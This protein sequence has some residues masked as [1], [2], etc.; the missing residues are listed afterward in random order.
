MSDPATGPS[1]SPVAATELAD[2][3]EVL[4]PGR[5]TRGGFEPRIT[6]E[7]GDGWTAEQVAAGFFD[8]Q[9]DAGS[10]DV[11]AVQF[12]R[13]VGFEAAPDAVAAVQA[14]AQL[15]VVSGPEPVTV[16]GM[17]GTRITVETTD[18]VDSQPPIF[19]QVLTVGAGPLS[20][21]SG[22][23][24]QVDLVDTPDGLLAVLVGGSI[25]RWDETIAVTDP[26]LASLTIGE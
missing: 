9:R 3:G 8:V 17:E 19:R 13:V 7:L 14:N 23:R 11:I 26:V 2:A 6:F 4:S 25:R 1:A 22:R 24:L 5:Y 10:L 21:A 20:I 15:H 18:P 16:G 12:A